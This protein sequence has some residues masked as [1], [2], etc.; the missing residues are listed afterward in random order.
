MISEKL[1]RELIVALLEAISENRL[2]ERLIEA[3]RK[4]FPETQSPELLIQVIDDRMQVDT[5]SDEEFEEAVQKAREQRKFN[6]R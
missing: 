5:L 4:A 3:T 1:S 6:N 2:T